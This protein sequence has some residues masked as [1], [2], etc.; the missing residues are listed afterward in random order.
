MIV[1]GGSRFELESIRVEKYK[2]DHDAFTS[3]YAPRCD[4]PG[5]Y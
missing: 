3:T 1:A 5:G 4:S 2:Y